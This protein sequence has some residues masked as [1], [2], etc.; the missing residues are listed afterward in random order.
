VT[1]DFLG[2]KWNHEM[3]AA[4]WSIWRRLELTVAKNVD[5]I[6]AL[7]GGKVL[8]K[9]PHV[10]GGAFGMARLAR[11]LQERLEPGKGKRP[12]RPT[13]SLWI[14]RPK[15]PMSAATARKLKVLAKQ[16]STSGRKVTATQIAA[17]LLE[18]ALA[19]CEQ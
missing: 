9:L 4:A 10:G 3:G 15:V 5:K 2:K 17:Q 12:G 16:A 7:V 13:D 6:A 1:L 18:E 19:R 14:H 8:G 11:M